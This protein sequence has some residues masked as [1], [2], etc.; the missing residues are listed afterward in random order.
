MME[1]PYHYQFRIIVIGD[2][3]VGK[4]SLLK[5][6]S[7]GTFGDME[8]TVGVDFFSKIIQIT[9]PRDNTNQ[10]INP[11]NNKQD[12]NIIVKLQIWDTA[13][14]ERFK[15]IVT[16]YYR[17]SVGI[18]LVY[19]VTNRESYDHLVNWFNEA[20]RH[21]EPSSSPTMSPITHQAPH[22]NAQ[23]PLTSTP[24]SSPSS[25]SKK[26]S[27]KEEPIDTSDTIISLDSTRLS[28]DKSFSNSGSTGRAIKLDQHD[29]KMT[30]LVLGC[31]T[32]LDAQRQVSYQDGKAF[33][34]LYGFK[35]IETSSKMHYN[36]DKAFQIL[37]EE[38][39]KKI[40]YYTKTEGS[41]RSNGHLTIDSPVF[42]MSEGIR[43]G[44][45]MEASSRRFHERDGVL[46]LEAQPVSGYLGGCC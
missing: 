5:T 14:Q 23:F 36:I 16:S 11:I 34:D 22:S 19:D 17:N 3:M 24:N 40:C 25:R 46:L 28:R 8:P 10:R 2:T 33:A 15:S 44:P 26:V 31:K 21:V 39:Y 30:Y 18:I 37:A 29:H 13:G 6:F 42:N 41:H 38:I 45:L 43:L 32:D 9:P 20:R 4:S 35:F 7:E 12:E 27:D 1:V